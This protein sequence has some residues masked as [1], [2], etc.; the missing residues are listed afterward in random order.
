MLCAFT[1]LYRWCIWGLQEG[2]PRE[3]EEDSAISEKDEAALQQLA[4]RPDIYQLLARSL[5]MTS[6][7]PTQSIYE[8]SSCLVC[9]IR[10]GTVP[11]PDKIPFARMKALLGR[12]G[13]HAGIQAAVSVLLVSSLSIG[14]ARADW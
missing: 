14:S 6:P 1:C 8:P 11:S 4:E 3:D 2:Q 10:R 7:P 5:G 9:V 12:T 13:Q